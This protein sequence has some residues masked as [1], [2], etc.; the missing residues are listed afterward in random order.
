MKNHVQ[1]GDI[2]GVTAPA[3]VL[4]GAGV[5]VGS[6]FGVAVADALSGTDVQIAVEGVFTLPKV[7]SQA[8]TVGALIYWNGTA[9]TNVASTNKLIGAA[10]VAVGSGAGETIG[11]VRLNGTAVTP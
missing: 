1:P 2:V 8:W 5:L 9:C 6:L 11:T 10:V 3:N 4:S 7:G